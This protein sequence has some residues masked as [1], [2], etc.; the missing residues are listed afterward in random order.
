MVRKDFNTFAFGPNGP[1][2]FLTQDEVD[3]YV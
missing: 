1:L 2:N 3:I